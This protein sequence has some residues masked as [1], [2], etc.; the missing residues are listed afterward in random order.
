VLPAW[1][2]QVVDHL[3]LMEDMT[4]EELDSADCLVMVCARDAVPLDPH[5]EVIPE[6]LTPGEFRDVVRKFQEGFQVLK[7][8]LLRAGAIAMQAQFTPHGLHEPSGAG[9]ASQKWVEQDGLSTE[10]FEESRYCLGEIGHTPVALIGVPL[11]AG[12]SPQLFYRPI[13]ESGHDYSQ[14]PIAIGP[15][16]D[17]LA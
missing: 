16:P 13:D 2:W 10:D 9:G 5:A 1:P 12:Y 17:W 15:D 11:T 7:I 14:P 6:R 3:S 8:D 4:I